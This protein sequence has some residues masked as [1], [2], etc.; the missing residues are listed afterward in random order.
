MSITFYITNESRI[1]ILPAE[2]PELLTMYSEEYDESSK[3][4]KRYD[5][6][7]WLNKED[8]SKLAYAMNCWFTMSKKLL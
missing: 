4:W 8:A 5:R 6:L 3:T 1:V 7:P 2:V